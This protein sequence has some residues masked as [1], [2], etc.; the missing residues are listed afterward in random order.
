MKRCMVT[1]QQRDWEELAGITRKGFHR[2]QKV[3]NGLILL[4]CDEGEFNER[5]THG[6]AIAEILALACARWIGSRSD[7]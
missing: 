4:N 2:L 5:R 6:E 3:L 1:L 7:A